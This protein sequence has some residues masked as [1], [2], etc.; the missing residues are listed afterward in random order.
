MKTLLSTQRVVW[1]SLTAL[2]LMCLPLR[3]QNK[4]QTGSSSGWG[5]TWDAPPASTSLDDAEFM[6]K[7]YEASLTE[8]ALGNLALQNASS[9]K[10]RQY[11]Q[12]VLDDANQANQ[13]LQGLARASSPSTTDVA[14]NA[15][16]AARVKHN[17]RT[18]HP[19]L[20][21]AQLRQ[22]MDEFNIAGSGLGTSGG[23]TGTAISRPDR[24]RRK[25]T[26]NADA[27]AGMGAGVPV[28]P[29]GTGSGGNAGDVTPLASGSPGQSS[30]YDATDQAR[31]RQA[32]GLSETLL[33]AHESLRDRL[34][35]LSGPE[36]D[37]QYLKATK[38]NHATLA[39]LLDSQIN[40][41]GSEPVRQWAERYQTVLRKHQP[42]TAKANAAKASPNGW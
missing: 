17:E 18:T 8:V 42:P 22:E 10:V 38:S 31:T 32:A 9:D 19:Y 15:T 33:P 35:V 14:A 40:G 30:Q 29:A 21:D 20:H 7:A 39:Q 1:L 41:N 16:D 27:Q 34:S 36:F 2:T 26:K 3:A 37:R 4:S 23:T 12:Q 24:P 13:A 6:Q 25:S 5:N 28:G 11:A